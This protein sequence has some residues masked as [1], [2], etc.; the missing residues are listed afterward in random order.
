MA[1]RREGRFELVSDYAPAGDQPR[2]IATVVDAIN[3]GESD[4]TMLGVTGS[5]KTFTMANIVQ[6][7][8]KPT[9][10]LAHNKTLAA[11]LVNE[12][13]EFFP[14]NAV[15]YFVSYYDYYQP[16]AYV[17][18]S[19]TFIEKDSSVNDEIERLRHQATM[20]LMTRNDVLIVASVSCI[21][22]LG[23]PELY[24]Q[25]HLM[26]HTGMALEIE[27]AMRRLVELQYSRNDIAHVRGTFRVRGDTLDVI[28]AEGETTWRLE[29]FGDEVE[30]ILKVNH[31][32][33]EILGE[34]DQVNIFPNTHYLSAGES[35]IRAIH[36]I[37][38]ELEDRLKYFEG[39][40][41]LL[42]AQRLRMRTNH[43]LEMLREIGM[44]KGIENYSRHLDG[45]KP[46][47]TPWTLLDYF[48]DDYLVII[49]ESHVTNPQ[50]GGQQAG[51][52]S[53]KVTLV[54]HGFRLPSAIDNRPLTFDEFRT[55]T[56][57]VLHVSATPGPFEL[58]VSETVAELVIRPTGLV[59]PVV[60]VCPTEGQIDDLIDKIRARVEVD[61]R[62]LVTTLTKKMAEDLTD[63]LAKAGIQVRYLHSDIDTVERIEI[64]RDLRTGKFDVLVGINL[65][66][67]GLDLP[68]VS[69]VA[70]L[71]ADKEG[72]LRSTTSLIQTIGRAARNANGA[73]TM[74]AD[75]ITDSMRAALDETERRR[76]LQ[77][78][79]NEEHGIVPQTIQK[80]VGDIIAQTRAEQAGEVYVALDANA[81]RVSSSA[82]GQGAAEIQQMIDGLTDEMNAAAA[83][84]KFELAAKLR[85]EIGELR[86][87][88]R[89]VLE[90]QS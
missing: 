88:L 23:S 90:A 12:F 20:G 67:E 57:Q 27:T 47:E 78:A 8:Q 5:G 31:L 25:Y 40:N 55:K 29:F 49:D 83:E 66:R 43:D 10:V 33:G 36:G 30:R 21:Y 38:E 28:S 56:N 24:E 50:I 74:Y 48:P 39:E 22:G 37:E 42:E 86:T 59:D 46:G 71:D 58:G 3:R 41:K 65:L 51:D 62:V 70:I 61:E 32:T 45:R 82:G 44:C 76:A 19:D 79:F 13:R 14:H 18:S 53:R 80:R 17:V 4:I 52:R 73:V 64:L 63:Y 16:E 75:T 87:N 26:V 1:I 34:F 68:E 6:A 84:L 72:F 7:V 35:L 11:Q 85:D 89:A 15:E 69:L 60:E 9:L 2:A 77:L 54:D 81:E